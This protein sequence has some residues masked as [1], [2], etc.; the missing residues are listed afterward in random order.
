MEKPREATVRVLAAALQRIHA[1]ALGEVL[2]WPGG[3]FIAMCIG[4]YIAAT[5][6][7]HGASERRHCGMHA[8]PSV[9]HSPP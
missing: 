4:L 6:L 3:F 9:L 5:N 2:S 7:A 1:D 8:R